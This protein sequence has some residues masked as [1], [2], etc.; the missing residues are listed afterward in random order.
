[1]RCESCNIAIQPEEAAHGLRYGTADDETDLFLPAR[2]SAWTV[3]CSL[4]GEKIYRNI[5][6][7]LRNTS[8]NPAHNMPLK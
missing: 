5:Y 7:S 6:A 8:I 4:C 1:M 3:L 2:E